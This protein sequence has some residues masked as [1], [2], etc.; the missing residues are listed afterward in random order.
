MNIRKFKPIGLFL[1]LIVSVS[2]GYAEEVGTIQGDYAVSPMGAGTYTI[3]IDLPPSPS[4]FQPPLNLTYN[5]QSGN[6]LLGLGWNLTGLSSISL[7]T[8]NNEQDG[9]VK[10]RDRFCLD[11]QKLIAK[12]GTYGSSQSTYEFESGPYAANIQSINTVTT[13]IPQYFIITQP[14]GTKSYYG[15]ES[16]ARVATSYGSVVKEWKLNKVTDSTGNTYYFNYEVDSI[17]NDHRVT[18]ITYG[19]NSVIQFDYEDRID[20]IIKYSFG[21]SYHHNKRLKNITVNTASSVISQYRLLYKSQVEL[22]QSKLSEVKKCSSNLSSDSCLK[23]ISLNWD[24]KLDW[25]FTKKSDYVLSN[26]WDSAKSWNVDLNG[27][28]KTDKL[29]YYNGYLISFFFNGDGTYSRKDTYIGVSG[30]DSKKLWLGDFNGDGIQD[31]VSYYGGKFIKFFMDGEGGVSRVEQSVVYMSW[32]T[33]KVWVGDYN[34]DGISD[35]VSYYKGKFVKFFMFE[36]GTN[37]Y[38]YESVTTSG[39]NSSKV[40]PGDFNGD[41][42]SDLISYHN[43]YLTTFMMNSSGGHDRHYT[44][45]STSYWDSNYTWPADVNGDGNTD[46]IV[47]YSGKLSTF[48]MKGNGLVDRKTSNISTSTWQRDRVWL[49]DINGDGLTDIWSYWNAKMTSFLM[50]GDGTFKE[51]NLAVTT[52]GWD[53]GK[54]WAGDFNGDGLIDVKSYHSSNFH[55]FI[56]EGSHGNRLKSIENGVGETVQFNYESLSEFG[57]EVYSK[58]TDNVEYPVVQTTR[59]IYAVKTVTV[60]NGIGGT[61]TTSYNYEGLKTHVNGLGSLGFKKVTTKNTQ[62]GSTSLTEYFQNYIT[63]L[64]GIDYQNTVSINGVNIKQS[65]NYWDV[66]YSASETSNKHFKKL[67]RKSVTQ[68]KA[69]SGANTYKSESLY[70]HSDY[71]LCT[72]ISYDTYGNPL[73]VKSTITD[74]QNDFETFTTQTTNEYWPLNTFSSNSSD[75]YSTQMHRVTVI[76][77]GS[78]LD[79]KTRVAEFNEYYA[80]GKLKTETIEPGGD[81]LVTK[82]EYEINGYGRITKKTVEGVNIDTRS[83]SVAYDASNPYKSRATNAL[84]QTTTTELSPKWGT[85]LTKTD[86]NDLP[87]T[88]TYDDFGRKLTTSLPDG[89]TTTYNLDWCASNCPDNALYYSTVTTADALS[90]NHVKTYFD[91]LQRKVAT[92]SLGFNGNTIQVDY[93]YDALGRQY[94]TSLP[95]FVDSETPVHTENTLYDSLSRVKEVTHPNGTKSS[96]SYDGFTTTYTNAKNQQKVMVKNARGQT[97]TSTDDDFKVLTLDYDALGN[98]VTTTD[99][100]NNKVVMTYDTRGNKTSMTDPDKGFWQYKYNELG[101]LVLQTDAKNQ[102]ICMAYDLLDRMTKRIDNYASTYANA[103]KHCAGDGSNN[104]TADWVYDSSPVKGFGKLHKVSDANGYSKTLTYD[105]LGRVSNKAITI[106]GNPYN[107]GKTYYANTS[108]VDNMSY[109]QFNGSAF[110]VR[111]TYKPSGFLYKTHNTSTSEIYWQATGM[112]ARG[113]LTNFTLGNG[114][115]TTNNYNSTTGFIEEIDSLKGGAT[116]IQY[117]SFKYDDVGNLEYRKDLIKGLSEQFGYDDLNRLTGSTITG[118]NSSGT[119]FREDEVTGYDINN[120]LGNIQSKTGVGAYTYGTLIDPQLITEGNCTIKTAGPHAVTYVSGGSVNSASVYCYDQNGDMVSGAGRT[121]HYTAFGKPYSISKGTNSVEFIYG[122][123]RARTQRIDNNLTTTTYVEGIYEELKTSGVLTGKYS[124]GNYAVV[125][126]EATSTTTHYLHRDHLGSVDAT[127]DANG[128]PVTGQQ[129]SFD[130]WGKRRQAAWDSMSTLDLFNFNAQITKRGYT[131]HEQVDSMGLIHMKGRMYDPILARFISADPL[132]QAPLD[133]QS[134]NRYSY[135][136]NNPLAYTDPTGYSWLSKKTKQLVNS[137][138]FKIAVAIT[139]A[140]FTYGMVNTWAAGTMVVSG[141]ACTAG[142]AATIAGVSGVYAGAAAGFVSGAIITGSFDGAMESGRSGAITGGIN[143]YT[144]TMSGYTPKMISGG[145]NGRLMTGDSEGG[146]RGAFAAFIPADLGM[147]QLHNESQWGNLIISSSADYVRGYT[148]NG[149]RG[150]KNNMKGG[151]LNKTAGHGFG[152]I[153]SKG[154]APEFDKGSGMY[155]YEDKRNWFPRNTAMT[156]GNVV[157][158]NSNVVGIGAN[159]LL[160]NEVFQHEVGHYQNQSNLG[161]NYLPVH[162]L[163]MGMGMLTQ[164][165]Y[166]FVGDNPFY[167]MEQGQ[168]KEN[169]YS[170]LPHLN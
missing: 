136:L 118:M 29:S 159:A 15:S 148:I 129:M 141:G 75:H 54:T 135:V 127:T 1:A 78:N 85:V 28:G 122:P 137:D 47:Y 51:E 101:Q 37:S 132:V 128:I 26:N 112:N 108:K 74:Q 146:W 96:I 92:T 3:P 164:N 11:G 158:G 95:Y 58:G 53:S 116:G 114:V 72:N 138:E 131:N 50:K 168:A 133:M 12:S 161:A 80:N 93:L 22:E 79:P 36:N 65:T 30:W 140:Y 8:A 48:I 41:G 52:S 9:Y 151:W 88:H 73:V 10:G 25:G 43:G 143:G 97:I 4:G 94:K 39:W 152:L 82:Y 27:D 16:D 119:A 98:L 90:Q 163:S 124:I 32:D 84:N 56:N 139:A 115:S 86:V 169:P 170:I 60:D 21:D 45:V 2:P 123:S 147:T 35:L 134:Y 49:G 103:L 157:T 6:G 63:R 166:D 7:C 154:T 142:G 5:S 117:L 64:Y 120:G 23:S 149:S 66:V 104:Q 62:T 162:G 130:A 18:S 107:I 14:N 57:K 13:N 87:V 91:A 33:T 153:S 42:V 24:G 67:L 76:K 40:W 155:L 31:L 61:N 19:V 150:G 44:Y 110:T 121:I 55:T 126:K 34:G 89:T 145:I 20:S 81:Q 105:S 111:N 83:S 160:T 59:P 106:D 165:N 109:P 68:N 77:D 156:I 100:A 71:S 102:S 38:S 144:S 99:E 70:C 17:S 167:F 125:T 113:R 69:L 46:L